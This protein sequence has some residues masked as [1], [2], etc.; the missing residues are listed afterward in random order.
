VH[1][2]ALLPNPLL[3][4]LRHV[5]GKSHSLDS[6]TDLA[7]LSSL[8]RREPCDLLVIDPSVQ[9]GHLAADMEQ[10]IGQHRSLPV[11]V[12]TSLVPE[13]MRGTM[14]LARVGV[15]H[16]VLHRFDDEPHRLLDLL[17]RTPAHPMAEMMLKELSAELHGLPVAVTRVIEQVMHSPQVVQ[18]SQELAQLAGMAARTLYRH[19]TPVGLSPRQLIVCA[20]LL[21]AYTLLREPGSRLKEITAKLGYAD[22]DTVSQ[23]V[24]EWTGHT[25]KELRRSVQPQELVRLLAGYMRRAGPADEGLEVG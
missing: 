13:A 9:H 24:Q 10:L 12:Y 4:H 18:N 1:V 16:V 5:L 3:T 20:R 22:P 23:L 21:R 7:A 19:L 6:A 14:R 8:L 11:V 2:A 25:T 17:E 15:R